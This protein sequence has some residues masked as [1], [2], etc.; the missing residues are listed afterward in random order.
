MTSTPWSPAIA[1]S[2][3]TMS[4][5]SLSPLK[6]AKHSLADVA[7]KTVKLFNWKLASRRIRIDGEVSAINM[8]GLVEVSALALASSS[9][10]FLVCV[11]RKRCSRFFSTFS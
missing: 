4:I 9:L 11:E 6:I 8:T 1:P 7:V 5:E 2:I 10:G 3:K